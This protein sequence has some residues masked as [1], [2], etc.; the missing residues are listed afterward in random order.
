MAGLHGAAL[1]SAVAFLVNWPFALAQRG[2]FS[3]RVRAATA[4]AGSTQPLRQ[5]QHDDNPCR[6]PLPPAAPRGQPLPLTLALSP[7]PRAG[8]S[9]PSTKSH[10]D[11]AFAGS[12]HQVCA[13]ANGAWLTTHIETFEVTSLFRT[14]LF[15]S[16]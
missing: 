13:A 6:R 15:A 2:E 8:G 3:P 7:P 14:L 1:V 9:R 16:L 11:L 12:I 4:A 10:V 5:W